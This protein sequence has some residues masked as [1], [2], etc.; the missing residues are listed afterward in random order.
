MAR[1]VG[2]V[3][4]NRSATWS[5]MEMRILRHY[6]YNTSKKDAKLILVANAP[7]NHFGGEVHPKWRD[8]L[9]ALTDLQRRFPDARMLT[10]LGDPAVPWPSRRHIERKNV[11]WPADTDMR[12][13]DPEVFDRVPP[14]VLSLFR[15]P[16]FEMPFAFAVCHHI[17]VPRVAAAPAPD[18][19]A[20]KAREFDMVYVGNNRSP[21]RMKRNALFL[22]DGSCN[23]LSHGLSPKV[24][25]G[26]ARHLSGERISMEE[27]DAA[28]RRA[29]FSL[30]TGDPRHASWKVGYTIRIMQTL[31]TNTLC[32]FHP[33]FPIDLVF[34][35][36]PLGE[37]L[38]FAGA[39]EVADFAE[40]LTAPEYESLV[41]AQR[42]AA[43]VCYRRAAEEDPVGQLWEQHLY[44]LSQSTS[45]RSR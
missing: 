36:D 14:L 10:R 7:V 1:V 27:V 29:R 30:I 44:G 45:K 8:A 13:I 24:C 18:F 33:E 2:E 19:G 12:R 23:T 5:S 43:E 42:E 20:W 37:R 17:T 38:V 25:A 11:K 16:P 26:W 34:A 15:E 39:R 3:S 35:G 28:H 40:S 4:F 21:A 6:A 41:R 9:Y 32:A 22:S 31:Q